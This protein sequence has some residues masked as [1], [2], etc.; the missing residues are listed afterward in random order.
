M[1]KPTI[2]TQIEPLYTRAYFDPATIN[3]EKRTVEVVFATDKPIRMQRWYIENS[4]D[5]ILSMDAGNV[6]LER[7][8]SGAPLLDNHDKYS[9]VIKSQFGVVEKAWTS[10]GEARA[11]VRYSKRADVEPVWQDVQDG[12]LKGISC[13]YRVYEYLITEKDG[14]VDQYRA[15]DW[16]PFEISHTQVPAD[17]TSGIRS[18]GDRI[19]IT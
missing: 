7:M 14:E 12:I 2:P 1:P 8:N 10:N 15:I 16:E 17:F 4:F 13:G 6:R 5:E 11:V 9:S 18:D 3:K 19:V